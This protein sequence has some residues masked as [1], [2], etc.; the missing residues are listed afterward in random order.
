MRALCAR[1]L[2]V[3]VGPCSFLSWCELAPRLPP[4]V[5]IYFAAFGFSDCPISFRNSSVVSRANQSVVFHSLRIHFMFSRPLPLCR[6]VMS[7]QYVLFVSFSSDVIHAAPNACMIE[8]LLAAVCALVCLSTISRSKEEPGSSRMSVCS[9]RRFLQ[10]TS[11]Y[12]FLS[13][14]IALRAFHFLSACRGCTHIILMLYTIL[15]ALLLRLLF[16]A[17]S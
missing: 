3:C 1:F 10:C 11:T 4:N 17:L 7:G 16:L 12:S 9:T 5:L 15:I 2:G 6:Q 14:L 13:C 8:C